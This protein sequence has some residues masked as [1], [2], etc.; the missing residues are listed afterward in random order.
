[1]N[2][3]DLTEKN[4]SKTIVCLHIAVVVMCVHT[5]Y[6]TKMVLG[7]AKKRFTKNARDVRNNVYKAKGS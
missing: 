4:G 7:N 1:M 5:L 3:T 6:L 2:L